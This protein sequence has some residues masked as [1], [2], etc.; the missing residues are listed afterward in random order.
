MQSK[1]QY[2]IEV[3]FYVDSPAAT[4]QRIIDLGATLAEDRCFE[5]NH[6]YDDAQDGLKRNFRLLR[7]RKSHKTTLTYKH[8]RDDFENQFK[9]HVLEAIEAAGYRPGED[10]AI[11]LDIAA[12]DREA[13]DMLEQTDYSVV[14]SDLL[15][16]DSNGIDLLKQCRRISLLFGHHAIRRFLRNR[17]VEGRYSTICRPAGTELGKPNI[18]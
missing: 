2:E 1:P 18:A 17:G 13:L 6:R 3:K 12:T 15:L 4:R 16:G 7:L 5:L 9:V 10:V 8:R 11:S 14:I